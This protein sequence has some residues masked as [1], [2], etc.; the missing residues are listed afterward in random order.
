MKAQWGDD[1]EIDAPVKTEQEDTT[2]APE[3]VIGI[4]CS[5]PFC[6]FVFPIMNKSSFESRFM[7]F[8]LDCTERKVEPS[9]GCFCPTKE[10]AQIRFLKVLG[11]L[12]NAQEKLS[13]S[14]PK[15]QMY[16]NRILRLSSLFR[17]FSHK[18]EDCY[19]RY[20]RV[21]QVVSDYLRSGEQEWGYYPDEYSQDE[22]EDLTKLA[23]FMKQQKSHK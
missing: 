13:V 16:T 20:R 3:P 8:V 22:K 6:D 11:Q 19:Q 9:L 14:D 18:K 4:Q 21:E 23:R 15:Y 5:N 12:Q 2:Q 1:E 10:M 17:L 7:S